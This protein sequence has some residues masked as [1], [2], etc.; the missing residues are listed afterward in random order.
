MCYNSFRN[1]LMILVCLLA[2]PLLSACNQQGTP[3][4]VPAAGIVTLNGEPVEEASVIFAPQDTTGA[5]SASAKTDKNGKFVVTTVKPGDG[6][7][8]GEYLVLITKTTVS[9]EKSK[10]GDDRQIV[11]HLPPKYGSKGTS[12]LKVSIPPKGDKNIELK[13]EGEVDLTPQKPETR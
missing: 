1:T 9:G 10:D 11:N 3:G 13:M 5:Q 6:M 8:P 7:L 12:D 4:C 2:L